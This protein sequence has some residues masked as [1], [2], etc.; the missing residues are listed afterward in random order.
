MQYISQSLID[1][2]KEIRRYDAE[3]GIRKLVTHF[4]QYGKYNER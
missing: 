1:I 2:L 3:L 4:A